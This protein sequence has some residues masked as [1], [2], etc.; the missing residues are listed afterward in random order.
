MHGAV[1][2]VPEQL[3]H[4]IRMQLQLAEEIVAAPEEQGIGSVDPEILIVLEELLIQLGG[5]Q[6][7]AGTRIPFAEHLNE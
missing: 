5:N 1:R 6:H 3:L 4:E 7:E 2:L